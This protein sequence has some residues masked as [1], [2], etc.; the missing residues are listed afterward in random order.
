MH[1]EDQVSVGQRIAVVGTTG[2]GKTTLAAALAQGIGAPHIE[3]DALFWGPG[4]QPVEPEH[5]RR[6]VAAATGGERWVTCGNYRTLVAE[7]VWRRADTLVWLDY[8]LPLVIARLFRRS[9]TRAA[10]GVELWQGNRE[11]WRGQ[12]LSRDS[13][14]VWAL[15]THGKH[16]REYPEMLARP[17]YAHLRVHRVRSPRAAAA[18]VG[19]AQPDA[20][21]RR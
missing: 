8:P 2:S 6:A 20:G 16:R 14:F 10:A 11:S 13:L 5:F 21:I 18:L 4:W 12:F 7:F 17:E 1:P 15:K 3:L 9:V 19:R